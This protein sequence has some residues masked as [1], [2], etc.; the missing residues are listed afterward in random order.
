[1]MGDE[2][3]SKKKQD[4]YSYVLL[5]LTTHHEYFTKE[6]EIYQRMRNTP[7]NRYTYLLTQGG[8]CPNM[9]RCVRTWYVSSG[10]Q[11]RSCGGGRQHPCCQ[12]ESDTRG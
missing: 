5:I 4:I 10:S 9:V 1:M 2:G 7:Q 11:T 6:K 12:C 3:V 8:V